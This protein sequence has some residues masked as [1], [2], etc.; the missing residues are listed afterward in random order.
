VNKIKVSALDHINMYVTDLHQSI[1]FYRNTFG[2]EI[3]E[4][5]LKDE[6]PWAIIGQEGVAYL[7]L[8]QTEKLSKE[9]KINHWGFSLDHNE[10]I[11]STLDKLRSNSVEILYDE[12]PNNGVIPWPKSKSIYILDPDGYEIEIS[13]DFGGNLK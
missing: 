10:N 1:K 3:K 2:F 4:D 8:Y 6:T 5:G 11:E 13:S 7:A 12:E 9:N